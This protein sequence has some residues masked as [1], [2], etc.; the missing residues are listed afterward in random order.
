MGRILDAL[1]SVVWAI[2][3]FVYRKVA[4]EEKRRE[5]E[6]QDLRDIRDALIAAA[7]IRTVGSAWDHEWQ[8]C[9]EAC[10]RATGLA[11]AGPDAGLRDQVRA[12]R[13]AFEAVTSN[14]TRATS[15]QWQAIRD[16]FDRAMERIAILMK[17]D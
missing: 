2:P 5:A 9:R 16:T 17:K 8:M 4:V 14:W 11:A 13:D 10:V 3:R 15:D 12:F 7:K 1:S 6:R